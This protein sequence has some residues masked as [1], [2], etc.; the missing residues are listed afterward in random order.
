[1]S[2]IEKM[3]MYIGHKMAVIL[4]K[5]DEFEEV[6][7]YGAI[8]FFQTIYANLII[9]LFGLICG[10]FFEALIIS[11]V[12]ALLRKYSGGVHASTANRCAILGG[13]IC[14]FLGLIIKYIIY[15]SLIFTV[16]F[17]A[18]VFI[19]VYYAVYNL[20]PVESLQ[21]PINNK[22]MRVRLKKTSLNIV[23]VFF[24]ICIVLIFYNYNKNIEFLNTLINCIFMGL[25]FQGLSLTKGAHKFLLIVDN[26]FQ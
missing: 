6:M 10:V 12:I 3:S 7:V 5:D 1:M 9:W 11:F 22:E 19:F 21:K 16:I 17:G 14:S 25:F 13:V 20:A 2:F 18:I 15:K 8:I 26:L 4:E 23:K 24:I